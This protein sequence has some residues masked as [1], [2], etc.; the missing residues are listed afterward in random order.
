MYVHTYVY[1]FCITKKWFI[2]KHL[3]VVYI[4]SSTPVITNSTVSIP[5]NSTPYATTST[6][7]IA[8]TTTTTVNAPTSM[9]SS[10]DD[11]SSTIKLYM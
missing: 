9:S 5:M 10:S 6:G 3:L 8:A 7:T 1:L 11:Q 2:N 4:A